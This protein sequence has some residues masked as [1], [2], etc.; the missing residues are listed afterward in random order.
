MPDTTIQTYSITVG[1]FIDIL[2]KYPR[3]YAL[4]LYMENINPWGG[5]DHDTVYQADLK[6]SDNTKTLEVVFSD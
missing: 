6:K 4:D 3:D 1:E 5:L 2:A